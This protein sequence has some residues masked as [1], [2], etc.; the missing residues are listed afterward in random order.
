MQFRPGITLSDAQADLART[1]I[2][3]AGLADR[4]RVEIRD[5]RALPADQ[6]FDKIASV[7]M[8]EHVGLEKLSTYFECL[9][10]ALTQNVFAWCGVTAGSGG[11]V[12]RVSPY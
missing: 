2:A 8:I 11:T 7:G 5:Y 10:R 3:E 6:Q 12:Y 9:H 1:R 4:C